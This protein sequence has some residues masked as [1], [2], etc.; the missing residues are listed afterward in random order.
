MVKVLFVIW[1]LERG[2]AERFLVS[3]VK[4]IDR[5]KIEPVVCCLNWKGEWAGEIENKDIKVIALNKKG[6]FDVFAFLKLVKIIKEGKFDI[7]NTHLWAADTIGRLA[8][9]TAGVSV[10]VSTAQNVDI[11]KRWWHKTIDRFLACKT[12]MIIAVSEAV[13]NYYNQKIRIPVSKI[14][15][16]PNAIEV[17]RFEESKDISYL[18]KELK[19]KKDDLILS[20]IGRL[21]EQKGQI[22]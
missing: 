7:V 1:S 22:Y 2:G 19:I 14:T 17:S 6:K 9:I 16:I 4:T 21:T 13:K 3:L 11:W 15:V 18:Y 20:C 12:D 8:A 5:T 10:I